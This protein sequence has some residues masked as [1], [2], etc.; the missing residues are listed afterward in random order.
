MDELMQKLKQFS[1]TAAANESEATKNLIAML[2]KCEDDSA[3]REKWSDIE[4][5]ENNKKVMQSIVNYME[6]NEVESSQKKD[7]NDDPDVSSLR[8]Y[9][10]FSH[11]GDNKN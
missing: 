3:L 4:P 10:I 2:L 11:K 6:N 5:T 9:S 1:N 7:Y 8:Q